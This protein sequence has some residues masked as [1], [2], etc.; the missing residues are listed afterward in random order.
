MWSLEGNWCMDEV[1]SVGLCFPVVQQESN[2]GG[3]GN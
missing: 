1:G 3:T 2:H